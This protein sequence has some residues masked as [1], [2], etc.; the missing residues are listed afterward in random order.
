MLCGAWLCY[1]KS[2]F[3][4]HKNAHLPCPG[5]VRI[6]VRSLNLVS[7]LHWFQS[8][9][10]FSYEVSK[11]TAANQMAPI[12]PE[13]RHLRD[14]WPYIHLWYH[15]SLFGHVARRRQGTRLS[16][17]SIAWSTTKQSVATPP[18]SR[19]VDQLRT[20]NNL[21]PADLWRRAVN[22]GHRGATLRTLPAKR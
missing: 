10:G 21:P 18:S 13:Q 4:R 19:W 15:Q 3:T 16:H 14:N 1:G 17:Q 2:S 7:S 5:A 9:R 6:I 8:P 22:R 20:D 12:H 11:A